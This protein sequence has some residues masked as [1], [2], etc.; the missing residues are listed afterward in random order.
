MK[1]IDFIRDFLLANRGYVQEKYAAKSGVLFSTKAHDTDLLT[2][3]DLTI[4]KR[5]VDR[6]KQVYPNDAVVGEEGEFS[7]FPQDP[8]GRVWVVDPIDGTYNFVRGIYPIF[9]ISIAFSVDGESVMA[10]ALLPITG[11]LFLAERGAGSFCNGQRLRVSDVQQVSH[12]RVDFDFSGLNDRTIFLERAMRIVHQ[13][14]QLRCYGSAVASLCHV[15]TAD[16]EAYVHMNL[17]PW[18]FAAAQ[19]IV[20]EAGGKSS[21]LDGSLLRLF[22]KRNGILI[23]NGTIHQE[24]VQLLNA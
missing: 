12:A 20:E 24:L 10:G 1:E 5:F 13:A 16:S 7:R 18:D 11:E 8:K 3:V 9:A 23:T 22:D 14:G 19:L 6:V 15:A 17:A 21:R 2:E 4:Q